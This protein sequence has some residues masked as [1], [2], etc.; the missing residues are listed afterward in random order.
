MEHKDMKKTY[1]SIWVALAAITGLELA[2]TYTGLS[3][4]LQTMAIA[5]LSVAK[6]LMVIAFFMHMLHEPKQ[7]KYMA[8]ASL[9]LGT[10]LA[11]FLI[12]PHAS[13]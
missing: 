13:L 1:V 12:A 9:A 10:I 2:I 3:K 5:G 8:L 4:A 6:A 11:F 7:L